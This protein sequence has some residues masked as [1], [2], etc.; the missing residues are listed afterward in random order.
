MSVTISSPNIEDIE[1]LY[2]KYTE[3]PGN[4]YLTFDDFYKFL[5]VESADRLLF[6]DEYCTQELVTVENTVILKFTRKE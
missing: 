2:G 3:I 5:S 4:E 1:Y 6:L